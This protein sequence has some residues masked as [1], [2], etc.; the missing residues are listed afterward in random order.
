VVQG[1]SRVLDRERRVVKA[2]V[3]PADP[4]RGRFGGM[5]R[6][7]ARELTA[8]V[9]EVTH[10]WF[11]ITLTVRSTPEG[12][13]LTGPVEFHL[14][15]TYTPQVQ[16]VASQKGVARLTIYG[17]GAFTVGVVADDGQTTLELNLASNERFP[18]VFRSR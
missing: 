8:K 2:P 17:Y 3:D 1:L 10:D 15:P 4:Q 18:A 12:K 9:E 13:P 14:H 16:K 5:A 6:R 7:N 11:E